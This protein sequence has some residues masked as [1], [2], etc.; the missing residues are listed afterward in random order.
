M[1]NTKSGVVDL[2]MMFGS[3][4]FDRVESHLDQMDF[5]LQTIESFM[6]SSKAFRAFITQC[7]VS[8]Q[9]N[10]HCTLHTAHCTLHNAPCTPAHPPSS[11]TNTAGVLSHPSSALPPAWQLPSSYADVHCIDDVMDPKAQPEGK[12]QSIHDLFISPIAGWRT[13]Y[14]EFLDALLPTLTKDHPDTEHVYECI[15]GFTRFA[16]RIKSR[17]GKHTKAERTATMLDQIVGIPEQLALAKP[18]FVA[19]ANFRQVE[20]TTETGAFGGPTIA[21]VTYV[22]DATLVLFEKY[23]LLCSRFDVSHVYGTRRSTDVHYETEL[24]LG[25][26][27]VR[28][29][30]EVRSHYLMSVRCEDLLVVFEADD[31][32]S[33]FEWTEAVQVSIVSRLC[34]CRV[35]L[36]KKSSNRSAQRHWQGACSVGCSAQSH[37]QPA[38]FD[39]TCRCCQLYPLGCVLYLDILC[40]SYC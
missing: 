20:L 24:P 6:R 22:Q 14:L 9:N 2:L 18:V 28:A 1:W 33:I 39:K 12:L 32:E 21:S 23:L 17:L 4:G 10:A 35:A 30:L 34:C 5:A 16:S 7:R 8:M 37:P 11:S 3:A 26:T 31:L 15:G 38:Q 13:V 40:F 19:K 27:D 36:S 29:M 25:V